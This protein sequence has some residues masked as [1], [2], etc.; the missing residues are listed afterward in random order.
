MLN[1]TW[2][3]WQNILIEHTTDDHDRS[4]QLMET[5]STQTPQALLDF[6]PLIKT[7]LITH[8]QPFSLQYKNPH[9]MW[10][11]EFL[12]PCKLSHIDLFITHLPYNQ[13]I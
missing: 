8:V 5:I 6:Q 7:L 10:L 3:R 1:V 13:F 9:K 2:N 4:S 11:Q 12:S